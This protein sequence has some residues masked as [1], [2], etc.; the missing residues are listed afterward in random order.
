MRFNINQ[1]FRRGNST[2]MTVNPFSFVSVIQ[3]SKFKEG[4]LLSVL[5]TGALILLKPFIQPLLQTRIP[6]SFVL[7]G[8]FELRYKIFTKGH[9]KDKEITKETRKA[10]I[11][12]H[13]RNKPEKG[14]FHNAVRIGRAMKR[15]ETKAAGLYSTNR[16]LYFPKATNLNTIE[17][18][19][20]FYPFIEDYICPITK[21]IF[22][23]P[24]TAPDGYTYER[25]A[26]ENWFI[27]GNTTC[28]M[29]TSKELTNP[30][31]I[32]TDFAVLRILTRLYTEY[33]GKQITCFKDI[34]ESYR[35]DIERLTGKYISGPLLTN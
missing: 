16:K 10:I 26:L 8:L 14:P 9:N 29:D 21:Q 18:F 6:I 24:V 13:K 23:E 22:V 7:L 27:A 4:I 1:L 17:G 3:S 12:A 25:K 32:P 15:A 35:K 31:L 28:P 20:E 30:A 5:V 2:H 33:K 19:R 34:E 11:R